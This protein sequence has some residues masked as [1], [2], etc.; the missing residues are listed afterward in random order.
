MI[1]PFSIP[2]TD[3]SIY[4]LGQIFGSVGTVL[5]SDT[6]S[7][8]LGAMFK[9]FNTAV[10][11]IAAL[12]VTYTTVVGVLKTAQEGKFLGEKW[13]S[14][15]VPLRTVAGIAAL[16]PTASGYC[17]I[18]IIMMWIIT[19]GV[20][21]AD[22]V[23]N[24][25][26]N[27]TE[28][29]GGAAKPPLVVDISGQM[30][31]LI[32]NMF[33]N[34]VCQAALVKL[35]S[36]NIGAKADLTPNM[37]EKK[38]D[39]GSC[40]SISWGG[41][42][43]PSDIANAQGK[44]LSGVV[45]ILGGVADN[46]VTQVMKD[47]SCWTPCDESA[48]PASCTYFKKY[49]SFNPSCKKI[50]DSNVAWQS[51]K[52][53]FGDINFMSAIRD[54][55]SATMQDLALAQAGS[56]PANPAS[57][58]QDARDN[59]WI[60]AGAYYYFLS[61]PANAASN[62]QD[63]FMF[64]MTAD[65]LSDPQKKYF[66]DYKAYP[67]L[68]EEDALGNVRPTIVKNFYCG[69]LEAD[70]SCSEGG[71]LGITDQAKAAMDTADAAKK[72][73]QRGGE[74]NIKPAGKGSG[75]KAD[76]VTSKITEWAMGAIKT[77]TQKIAPTDDT[78]PLVKM[79]GFGHTLLKTAEIMFYGFFGLALLLGAFS[80]KLFALG[81][82]LNPFE[83]IATAAYTYLI[84][85][86]F[87]LIMWMAIIGGLLGVYVPLLP[88]IVFTFG[89]ITW[90]IL[91]I[92]AMIAAPIVALGI[93]HPEGQHEILGRAEPT[94]MIMLSVFLR[95]TLMVFGM[96]AA[97]L[98]SYVVIQFINAAFYSVVASV[99]GDM[100]FLEGFF[101]IMVYAGLVIVA[102]NK[103]FAMIH[104]VPDRVL[105]W[106]GGHGE[107]LGEEGMVGEAKGMVSG[108]GQAAGQAAAGGGGHIAGAYQAESGV[109]KKRRAKE[110]KPDNK[111]KLGG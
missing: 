13:H 106:V 14:L 33:S 76:I 29:H 99:A 28:V 4:Y 55:F 25:A 42:D 37:A 109:H 51:V 102:L 73:S 78:N 105:R 64:G 45:G 68:S 58:F 32:K 101:Y 23:W 69:R 21:A 20:G 6:G 103:C 1:D 87:L 96:M 97:M 61:Q 39:L 108:A 84:P 110:K 35:D 57:G 46:Y 27:Y 95:P 2:L 77:W 16:M 67:G 3:K 52:G 12:I 79:Q 90:F 44:A 48:D 92:E 7:G 36:K 30:P 15:W 10:L 81:T 72:Q 59:G 18:Q 65:N 75:G 38:Y 17:A 40:G 93:I 47:P 41:S 104:M 66:S 22:A 24:T 91:T 5:T 70:G 19:Q 88:Y 80:T 86:A 85:F 43:V 31:A 62:N 11:S 100:G 50:A 94:L 8:L 56:S 98:L 63:K 60:F 71:A 9:T 74:I 89:A 82:T 34:L 26:V 111:S 54:Q 83:G 53:A 107:Q 49:A